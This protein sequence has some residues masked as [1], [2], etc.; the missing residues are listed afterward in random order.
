M[1]IE[2]TLV[3]T[4]SPS[5]AS[6]LVSQGFGSVVDL[7]TSIGSGAGRP[8]E[9]PVLKVLTQGFIDYQQEPVD[10]H[11]PETPGMVAALNMIFSTLKPL[12]LVVD[13]VEAW[14]EELAC[15]GLK[16]LGL[17]IE[18]PLQLDVAA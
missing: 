11:D 15:L 8:I 18:A 3:S 16:A 12:A 4:L 10:L 14:R 5:T 2:L 17:P 13:D 7:R 9:E 1:T 6:R